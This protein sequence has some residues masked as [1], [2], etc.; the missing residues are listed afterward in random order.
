[1]GSYFDKIYLYSSQIP[2]LKQ[3]NYTS[4]SSKPVPFAQ[5]LPQS[6]GLYTPDL[7]VDANVMEQFLNRDDDSLFEGD[8]NDTKNLIYLNL[9]NNLTNI[10]K[11]KATEKALRNVLRCFNVDERLVKINT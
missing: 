2:K 10:Y 1:M 11:S 4:A 5:H 9:Y 7:F 3:L 6:L 8:L